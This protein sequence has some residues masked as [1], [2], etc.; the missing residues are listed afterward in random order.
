MTTLKA[1]FS[2]PCGQFETKK[3]EVIEVDSESTV[4]DAF[5]VL[6][7]NNLLS[8]PCYNKSTKKYLG[9]LFIL[10]FV[11]KNGFFFQNFR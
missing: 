4:N 5:K 9:F 10:Y 3:S 1:K 6:V 8:V 11:G 2:I 7:A